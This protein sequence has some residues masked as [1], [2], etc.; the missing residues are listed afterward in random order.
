MKKCEM[1]GA[2]TDGET[3]IIVE[4]VDWASADLYKDVEI[5]VC[6]TCSKTDVF[7]PNLIR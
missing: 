2:E 7:Q 4:E 5:V 1:C 3:T 6:E